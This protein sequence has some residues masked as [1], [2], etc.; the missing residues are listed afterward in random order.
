MKVAAIIRYDS[1]E[2]I[3]S[4]PFSTGTKMEL[5]PRAKPNEKNMMPMN[6]NGNTKLVVFFVMGGKWV[7][8]SIK[9]LVRTGNA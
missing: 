7:R 2:L 4:E 1:A 9:T 6:V 3:S 8:R 5:I